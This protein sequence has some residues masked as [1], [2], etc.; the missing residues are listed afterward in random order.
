MIALFPKLKRF[1][2][3]YLGFVIII[4]FSSLSLVTLLCNLLC[5]KTCT[6]DI[7]IPDYSIF[8]IFFIATLTGIIITTIQLRI[9][10][11]KYDDRINRLQVRSE[12]IKKLVRQIQENESGFTTFQ[13]QKKKDRRRL[14]K[15]Y[16]MVLELQICP[17]TQ[18][19]KIAYSKFSNN[20]ITVLLLR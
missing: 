10:S 17:D 14:I 19:G 11:K 12:K 9:E 13:D 6:Q 18:Y 3:N 5:N 20:R 15:L 1:I 4:L 16:I 7:A 2:L 8:I